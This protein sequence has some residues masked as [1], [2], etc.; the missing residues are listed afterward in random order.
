MGFRGLNPSY[1][2]RG[3]PL[4]KGIEESAGSHTQTYI[5]RK[6]FVMAAA[7]MHV[8]WSDCNKV[9]LLLP[10]MGSRTF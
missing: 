3:S 4:I 8:I 1:N 6:M 9:L 5:V 2:R 7:F 10:Q